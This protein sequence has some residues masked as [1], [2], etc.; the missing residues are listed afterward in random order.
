MPDLNSIYRVDKFIV[1]ENSR[2]EFLSRIVDTHKILR[3]QPGFIQDSILEQTDGPGRYNIVT[4]A[5][6]ESQEAI[7][8]AK[9]IVQ[10]EHAKSGF[11]PQETMERLGVQADIANYTR[12]IA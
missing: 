12:V 6:W 3:V 11:S 5:E 2:D 10:V 8:Y 1:P 4:V 7:D 9:K